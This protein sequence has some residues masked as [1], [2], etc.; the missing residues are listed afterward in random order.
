MSDLKLP[1]Q[2]SIESNDAVFSIECSNGGGTAIFGESFGTDQFNDSGFGV[3]GESDVGVGVYGSSKSNSGVVGNSVSAQGV[4]GTSSQF[5]AIVG[6]TS[7]D[8][9]AGVTGRNMTTGANGGVGLY[10]T[11]G[12]YAG[13]FDGPVQVNGTLI[14]NN[15][16]G[17][18]VQATS[19]TQD[20]INSTS[21]SPLHAG[22]SAN[23]DGGGFGVWA[24]AK[25]AGYF[26]GIVQ[27]VGS[28]TI[29][30]VDVLATLQALER[31]AGPGPPGPP[32]PPGGPGPSGPPG[33]MAGPPGPPGPAGPPGPFGPGGGPPG[34]PGPQGLPGQPGPFGPPGPPGPMG[35]PGQ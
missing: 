3:S 14:A 16:S 29:N 28:L 7:S 34:P 25:Y 9:H 10:G 18:A 8:A 32:G 27:V 21:S 19:M 22:V 12:Q 30:G 15:G 23:N 26:D 33:L 6:Q 20:A 1:Y 2:G 17:W 5:D 4:Y 31:A 35:E 13:K 24:K 11:G